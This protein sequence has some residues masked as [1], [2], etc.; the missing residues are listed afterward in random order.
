MAVFAFAL[1]AILYVVGMATLLAVKK[2]SFKKRA[3]AIWLPLFG[4]CAACVLLFWV[5]LPLEGF[6]AVF[7]RVRGAIGFTVL[8]GIALVL[9]TLDGLL[10]RRG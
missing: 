8:A 7:G 9:G 1:G 2:S 6:A 3:L 5:G 4:L 10:S